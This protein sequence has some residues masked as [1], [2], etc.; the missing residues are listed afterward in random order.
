[1]AG[2][3]STAAE[4][5]RGKKK[6]KNKLQHENIIVCPIQYGDHKYDDCIT[7]LL[8]TVKDEFIRVSH[9][10]GAGPLKQ[11]VAEQTGD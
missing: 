4:I 3:Q 10:R 8:H 1:M 5:R 11:T 7:A 6:K 2:I 9:G